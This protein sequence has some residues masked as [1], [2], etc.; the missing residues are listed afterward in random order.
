[1]NVIQSIGFIILIFISPVAVNT[2][3]E[4]GTN[5][6]EHEMNLLC[7]AIG[8]ILLLLGARYDTYK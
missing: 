1:M 3:N 8:I 5:S 2:L 6:I 7:I 4:F